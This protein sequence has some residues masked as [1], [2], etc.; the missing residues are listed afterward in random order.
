MRQ[1]LRTVNK[2]TSG[3]GLGFAGAGGLFA[4]AVTDLLS[5]LGPLLF[6]FVIL[7]SI[8]T[9]LL[10]IV[11]S[12]A[13]RQVSTEST[14][15]SSRMGL[16]CHTFVVLLGSLFGAA[17]LLASS[18]FTDNT[19]GSN[20]IALVNNLRADV[21][22]VEEKVDEVQEG[23]E[24]IG[25]AIVFRD[26]S[27]RSGTG[28][29]GQKAIFAVTLTNERRMQDVR[30]ELAIEPPWSDHVEVINEN[31]DTFTVQLPTAPVLDASGRSLGEI[32]SIPFQLSVLDADGEVISNYA[33]TYPLHNNYGAINIRVDP[34]GNRFRIDET[35]VISVDVGD[36]ML[37]DAVEC[38]WTAFDP[39]KIKPTST[40]GCVAEL[41]THTDKNSYVYRRLQ[42][43]G[44]I[45]DDIY[46]QINSAADF[47]MLG[48]TTM[49]YLI[50]P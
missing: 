40:N 14:T 6:W 5:V 34:P 13:G 21:Q 15:P 30:C 48:N 39:V 27:G 24:G 41:D 46:V 2:H 44:K 38:E 18:L 3:S 31:C 33:S 49:G 22:R 47:T 9:L 16:Y 7:V 17:V 23:V 45:R 37:T 35:R 28:R 36:A 20:I 32:V 12:L 1:F 29:I 8:L 19:D 50:Q 26:I 43:E 10:G 11:I 4:S 42:S 25:E